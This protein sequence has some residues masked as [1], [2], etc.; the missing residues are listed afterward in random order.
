MGGISE[1]GWVRTEVYI[2][3]YSQA[4]EKNKEVKGP[5]HERER[6]TQMKST[7]WLRT[8]KSVTFRPE[9][10]CVVLWTSNPICILPLRQRVMTVS[11]PQRILSI[12]N[13][14]G[15]SALHVAAI[16]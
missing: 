16:A 9:Y 10:N 7:L 1:D 8:F 4:V 5:V 14:A 13:S 12:S 11:T 15:M 3:I 6:Q 2:Y